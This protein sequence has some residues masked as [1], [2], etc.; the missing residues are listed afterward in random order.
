MEGWHGVRFRKPVQTTRETIEIVRTVSRGERLEHAG[1]IYPLPLP[2]SEGAAI[3]PLV[4]PAHVPGLRRGH[5]SGQPPRSPVSW[6]TAG[7]AT[8]S[9]R[10]RRRRSCGPLREGAARAGRSLDE[11]DLVAPVAVELTTDAAATEEAVAPAR[12]RLRLHHRRHG[13][14]GS[15]LLQRR[16]RPPRLRRRGRRRCSS[17]GRPADARRRRRPSRSTSVG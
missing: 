3:R 10:G 17:C 6:P 5:G 8:P 1:E 11:L 12:R 9:S 7:W 15:Q 13:Q 2:D 16:V 14:P 4:A